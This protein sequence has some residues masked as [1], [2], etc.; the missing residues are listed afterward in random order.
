MDDVMEK[1]REGDVYRWRYRAPGDDRA[2]GRYHCCSCIAIVDK[3]GNLRDTFWASGSDGRRFRPEDL[4][5][6]ELTRL[7]NLSELEKAGEHEADYYDDADIV[8]LNHSNSSRGNF[9]LR[10][11]AKRSA[12]KMLESARHKLERAV[13]DEKM[14]A[15]RAALLRVTIA[16]IEAGSTDMYF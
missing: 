2:Y 5:L 8:D 16:K 10:K 12:A 4:P 1:L 7:A 11:G 15:Q 14:A 3:D 9:Y 6:L 13:S